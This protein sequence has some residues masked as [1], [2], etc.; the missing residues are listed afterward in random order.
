A[1]VHLAANP[2]PSASWESLLPDNFITTYNMFT[3]AQEAGC[4]RLIFAS[5]I[6]AVWNY[7]REVVVKPDMP[8]W[9]ENI[10]GVSKCFGE[11]LASSLRMS[12]ACRTWRYAS[13]A[14]GRMT[15]ATP[16]WARL[17]ALTSMPTT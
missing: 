10:Y 13:A 12:A 11:A 6:H 15:A 3:A 1:V 14:T 16:L 17:C 7:P 4:R 2:D 8:I 9:P 5:S